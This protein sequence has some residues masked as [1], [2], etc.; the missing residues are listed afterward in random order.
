[1]AAA[2]DE[3]NAAT[4]GPGLSVAADNGAHQVVSGP[5]ADIE[6]LLARFEADE[7]RVARLRRSPDY[8]SAMIEPALGDLE[9]A[10]SAIAFQ[11]PSLTFVSNL[12]GRPLGE[13]E[14]PDAAYWRWQAREPVAFRACVETL[15]ELGVDAVIE[16]G[17]HAVLGPIPRRSGT[18]PASRSTSTPRGAKARTTA[19][20][21]STGRCCAGRCAGSRRSGRSR[22]GSQLARAPFPEPSIGGRRVRRTVHSGNER[23]KR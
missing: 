14:A 16:I 3:L 13:G 9:A 8:H 5:K 22:P 11:P 4:G 12:T 2:V 20:R 18:T 17:P 6:A 19:H 21:L 1:M 15:A 23:R 10:I 7:V